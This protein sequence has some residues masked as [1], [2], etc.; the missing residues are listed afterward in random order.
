MGKIYD[1]NRDFTSRSKNLMVNQQISW[2]TL[3]TIVTFAQT[4]KTWSEKRKF[5]GFIREITDIWNH[6]MGVW[7]PIT[8]LVLYHSFISIIVFL[9]KYHKNSIVDNGELLRITHLYPSLISGIYIIVY[10]IL[11]IIYV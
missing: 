3:E 8:E 11:Y 5:H 6:T 7:V 1:I 9:S 2:G 4:T 10:Y